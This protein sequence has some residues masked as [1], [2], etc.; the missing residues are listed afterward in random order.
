MITVLEGLKGKNASEKVTYGGLIKTAMTGN[1]FYTD[2]TDLVTALNTATGNLKTANDAGITGDINVMEEVFDMKVKLI[3]LYVQGKILGLDDT[4]AIQMVDSAN[5][6]IKRI[7]GKSI[8]LF[9]A[10]EGSVAGSLRLRR[11]IPAELKKKRIA[12]IFQKCTDPSK[13]ENWDRGKV[14][15]TATV[16]ITG[17]TSGVR[18]YFRVA[19]VVGEN[20]GDWSDVI[21]V[22]KL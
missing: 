12:F 3:V 5:L 21:T 15:T 20:Q 16:T 18:Y 8:A 11:L 14:T 10:K 9:S 6:G 4:I 13:E 2:G 22:V 1:A 19:I 17:L 7:T